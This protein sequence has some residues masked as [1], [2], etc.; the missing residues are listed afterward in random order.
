MI[1]LSDLLEADNFTEAV[2]SSGK[3]LRDTYKLPD[4]AQLGL[5]VASAE[6][7]D[8]VMFDAGLP[9]SFL[10]KVKTDQWI[11]NGVEKALSAKL[12]FAIHEGFEME[13]I[14]PLANAGFYARDVDPQDRIFVHH[15]GF[16]IKDLEQW[17]DRL[18]Q[19]DVPLLVRGK[20]NLGIIRA[21]FAYFDTRKDCDIISELISIR[22]LGFH[23]RLPRRLM[24]LLARFQVKSRIRA[25]SI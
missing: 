17:I 2:K 21:D 6:K 4:I 24:A 8:A 14:E 7:A 25:F 5:V 9:H 23:A 15:F 1:Y 11:E 13:L 3:K 18:L 22:I 16:M 19:A 10:V 20:L 12:G